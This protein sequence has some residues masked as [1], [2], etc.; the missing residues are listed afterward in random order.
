[1]SRI[2][3]ILLLVFTVFYTTFAQQ[4]PVNSTIRTGKLSNG[5]TYY[6]QK[7]KT[8]VKKV[9]GSPKIPYQRQN[10]RYTNA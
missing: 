7:S 2:F 6:I 3:L 8:P 5:L 4:I 9:E 10:Y 1:M